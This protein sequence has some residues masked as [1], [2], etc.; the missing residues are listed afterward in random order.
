[1]SCNGNSVTVPDACV[2]GKTVDLTH[3]ELRVSLQSLPKPYCMCHHA[4]RM[5]FISNALQD[6]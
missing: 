2:G 3:F 6:S 4:M 1:M 5:L